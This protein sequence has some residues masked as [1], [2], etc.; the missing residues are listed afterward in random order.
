MTIDAYKVRKL[1]G[2]LS[3]T[4]G[5]QFLLREVSSRLHDRLSVMKVDAETLADIGCGIGDDLPLLKERFPK[6]DVLGIDVA[7]APLQEA[8]R[9][10]GS[11]HFDCLCGDAGLLPLQSESQDLVWSNMMLHWADD[12]GGVLSEWYRTLRQ[13]GLLMFSCLGFNSLH[14]LYHAFEGID[15]YGHVMTFPDFQQLGDA[16]I[17]TGFP[18]PVI[19]HEW[20][21]LTYQDVGALLCDVRAFGGN[22]LSNCRQGL[23]GKGA[24]AQ[25]LQNLENLRDA[26]GK[27]TLSFEVVFA[28]AFKENLQQ[29]DFQVDQESPITFYP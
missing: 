9:L 6:A 12:I 5:G 23:M 17:Q 10:Y 29:K 4:E 2:N 21:D 3:R 16:L 1:F 20:I 19:E 15:G 8:M 7:S 26:D 13:D 25:V 18:A 14:N 22:P 11:T 24:F 28:H 27:I